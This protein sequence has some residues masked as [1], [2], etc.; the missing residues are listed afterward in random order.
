MKKT[1]SVS[2]NASAKE[3][4]NVSEIENVSVNG[5]A[6]KSAN[7]NVNGIGIRI[8]SENGSNGSVDGMW[9][10]A[11]RPRLLRW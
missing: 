8:R 2:V 11:G 9:K 1:R 6:T 3:S 10:P 5:I 4:E 7:G